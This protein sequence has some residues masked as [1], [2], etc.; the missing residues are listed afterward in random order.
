MNVE[1]GPDGF[2]LRLSAQARCTHAGA[3]RQ[4]LDAGVMLR[5]ERV[6]RILSFGN[7]CYLE[8]V[9]KLGGQVLQ[10]MHRQ[11]NASGRESL[12]DFFR[13]HALGADLGE[14]NIGDLVAGGVNDL[15]LDFITTFAQRR[16]NVVGLPKG[17]LRAAGANPQFCGLAI[18]CRHHWRVPTSSF[19]FG[20]SCNGISFPFTCK[21][22]RRF[23][24]STTVVASDS[25]AALF[26]VVIGVCITLLMMPRV[27]ASIAISCSGVSWPMRP[28]TRSISAC[29]IVSRWSCNETIVGTTSSVLMR[30]SNFSTSPAIM[31]S[32]RSAS[33][34]RSATWLVTACCRSSMSYAK[35]PS[36]FA[37]PCE[38][39]R[40][41]AISMKN[42]G[43]FLRR[44]RN[45]SPCSRRKIACGAPVEVITMSALS[46][47][48]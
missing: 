8:A 43:R 38:T 12:L 28:R 36:S 23:T 27:S 44:A 24:T 6:P 31:A 9:R 46:H 22:K 11:I 7:R 39:S 45:C 5:T 3:L 41:T 19:F 20:L 48:L 34:R 13:E 21:L 14:R 29:R 35:M 18:L 17:K 1:I 16:G 25:L 10:R 32:A 33:F 4:I 37:I 15:D 42:I 40:G 2:E 47:V 30:A 26:S